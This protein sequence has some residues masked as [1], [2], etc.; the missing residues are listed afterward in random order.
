MQNAV[1][2]LLVCKR[3]LGEQQI[4]SRALLIRRDLLLVASCY[5][6]C[7]DDA[8]L[9]EVFFSCIPMWM[10]VLQRKKPTRGTG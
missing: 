7:Q 1:I 5:C 10:W 4:L 2:A 9:Q 8:A 3:F 6:K